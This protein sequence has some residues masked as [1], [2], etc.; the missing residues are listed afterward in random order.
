M[1]STEKNKTAT[2]NAQLAIAQSTTM[3][4][5]D[6]VD[7]LRNLN[8]LTSTAMGIALAQLLATGDPKYSKVIEE[9]QKVAAKGVQHMAEVGK[10]AAKILQDFSK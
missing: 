1:A 8:T 7:N 5:Q 9:S 4:V 6:A 3:A 10:E 2:T